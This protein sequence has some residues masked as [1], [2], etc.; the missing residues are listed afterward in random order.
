MRLDPSDETIIGDLGK[1][2]EAARREGMGDIV[3]RA[4][5][6]LGM[7]LADRGRLSEALGHLEIA[8]GHPLL[9]PSAHPGAYTTLAN[10]Y[11]G[12]GRPRDA[13]TL[14]R[15]VLSRIPAEATALRTIIVTWLSQALA[16]LG[17]FEEAETVLDESIEVEDPDPNSRARVH[18][19]L[20][21]LAAMRGDGRLALSYT[22]EAIALL[23]ETEDT[24]RLARAHLL[25]S[26]VL[27]WSGKTAGV[28]RYL[29]LARDLFPSGIEAVD[30]G[31]LLGNEALLAA[32]QRRF[33]EAL[34]KA[35]EALELL[36]EHKLEQDAA[37]YAKALALAASNDFET[38]NTLCL[39]VIA[40]C[41]RAKLWHEAAL[42]SRDR[43]EMLKSAG[44]L[45]DSREALER[46]RDYE[47]RRATVFE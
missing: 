13:V 34:S 41:E 45:S 6:A 3:A 22:R 9:G 32:R 31:M 30:R 24:V 16:D 7:T 47:S 29:R 17:E 38:A 18:W 4:H 40:S 43:A 44:R 19:L 33:E 25:A 37:I 27:L 15:D 28:A 39:R 35:E 36:P 1:L 8:I 46:A 23:K 5:A 26:S 14:C 12:L 11:C 42:V 20:A 21:R 2:I 10:A